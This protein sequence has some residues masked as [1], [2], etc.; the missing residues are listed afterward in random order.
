MKPEHKT[1]INL[2]SDYLE[3]NPEQR[4]SQALFNLSINQFSNQENPE[5]IKF[6]LRDIYSD[7]DEDVIKRIK[8]SIE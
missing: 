6:L 5:E 7:S 1:I 3:K 8:S 2:I 4:F